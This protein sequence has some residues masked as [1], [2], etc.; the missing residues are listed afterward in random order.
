MDHGGWDDVGAGDPR[1]R[2]APEVQAALRAL[3]DAVW[4]SGPADVLELSR[5]RIAMLLGDDAELAASPPGAPDL[6]V[7]TADLAGWPGSG[8]VD[9]R[10]RAA[11]ALAEQFVIDVGGVASGPLAGAAGALGPDLLAFVQGLWTFDMGQ[12]TALA[13]AR[14]FRAEVAAD[15]GR[16]VLGEAPGLDQAVDDLLRATARLTAL[17]PVTAE[18]VRLRGARHHHCRMC[19]SVRSVDALRAGGGED[20]YD[21]I[22]RYE[23][24]DLPPRQKVALSLTDAVITQPAAMPDELVAQVHAHLSPA[25]AVELVC[26]V[27]RNG[28]NKIA[29]AFAA[30]APRVAEGFDY[31][32]ITPEGETLAGVDWP[33]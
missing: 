4:S 5:Q 21:R 20:L 30:D 15:G 1:A 13:L 9:D 25:E 24:A 6:A 12:R 22:D 27:M 23:H 26:D 31:Q 7:T 11:L 18:L 3:N 29:V 32:E 2:H 14:L 28:A 19:Q 33:G 17:D 8:R 10:Q 16:E